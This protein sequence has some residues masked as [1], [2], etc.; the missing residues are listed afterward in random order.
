MWMEVQQYLR[1]GA[2]FE[3]EEPTRGKG[4]S[5]GGRK[6]R[7]SLDIRLVK[8]KSLPLARGLLTPETVEQ[9]TGGT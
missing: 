8:W 3:T 2:K 7:R 1:N 5:P 9:G 6:E 4:G